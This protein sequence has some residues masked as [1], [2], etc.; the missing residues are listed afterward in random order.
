MV[1]KVPAKRGDGRSSFKKLNGYIAEEQRIDRDTGELVFRDVDSETNCLSLETAWKEM[2]AVGDMNPRVVDPVYHFVLSWP[3]SERPTNEEM[4]ECGRYSLKALGME[5]HQYVAAIH[6]DTDNKHLHV[7][8]NRV[9]PE[10]YKPVD[11]SHDFFKLHKACR[12]LE[13][14]HGW[15]HDKG[16]YRVIERDGQKIVERTPAEDRVKSDGQSVRGKAG[17]MEIY[18]GN[19]SLQRYAQGTPKKE[20]LEVLRKPDAQWEDLHACLAKHGLEIRPKGQGLGI[21]S[22]TDPKQMPIKAST[23]ATELG[24]G[25]IQKRL[26]EY[27]EPTKE[28]TTAQPERSYDASHPRDSR[29]REDAKQRRAA[30][31]KQFRDEYNKCRNEWRAARA[32][33]RA[34]MRQRHRE[35]FQEAAK[36]HKERRAEIRNSDRSATEKKALYSLA[37]FESMARK[38]Q[39]R[40]AAQSERTNFQN[41]A[42]KSFRDW[43]I[44]KANEGDAVALRHVRG[45]VMRGGANAQETD[46]YDQHRKDRDAYRNPYA[47]EYPYKRRAGH[48]GESAARNYERHAQQPSQQSQAESINSLRSLSGLDLDGGRAGGEMLLPRDEPDQL[49]HQRSG[50]V[51]ALR[52]ANHCGSNVI[53]RQP[54]EFWKMEMMDPMDEARSEQ[55]RIDDDKRRDEEHRYDEKKRD[56]DRRY[57]EKRLDEAK[58]YDEEKRYQEKREDEEKR[59]EPRDDRREERPEINVTYRDLTAE[60]RQ[61]W[62]QRQAQQEKEPGR[63]EFGPAAGEAFDHRPLHLHLSDRM[64]SDV[65]TATGHVKYTLDGREAFVDRG[66]RVAYLG[67]AQDK[68]AIEA[69][70][71]FAVEKFGKTIALKER[72]GSGFMERVL[73]VAVERKLDVEFSNPELERRRKEGLQQRDQRDAQPDRSRDA[74][75][76]VERSKVVVSFTD[77]K[78]EERRQKGVQQQEQERDHD[79]QPGH[80]AEE[81]ARQSD[82]HDDGTIDL[83]QMR[84]QGQLNEQKWRED[85]RYWDGQKREGDSK[86]TENQR[87]GDRAE[88]GDAGRPRQSEAPEQAPG[89]IRQLL[90]ERQETR[91]GQGQRGQAQEA[92]QQSPQR[93]STEQQAPGRIRQLLNERQETQSQNI[94]DH[95]R[96]R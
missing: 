3:K 27:R 51:D 52:R 56:E 53:E 69:G 9:N 80:Q 57:D 4:Y 6:N 7:S 33:A 95:S 66:D 19:E 46:I 79:P 43:T 78:L 21:Y 77:P 59:Y 81:P 70:T 8:A 61:Q 68:D 5:G 20:V 24:G 40:S 26:G 13:I 88:R 30:E 83:A 12:E 23:M 55:A 91:E 82:R 64:Q 17:E 84:E 72:E 11:V 92:G 85:A 90:N 44:A 16:A 34:E 15:K 67:N 50:G 41:G 39:L 31:N 76:A 94:D 73:E 2:K 36:S 22:A 87:D 32:P 28:I 71:K 14:E 18:T 63:A 48:D 54:K 45:R 10:T 62:E 47:R 37:A 89:R 60:Q 96:S 49:E 42:V 1:P 35:Q 74:V 38:E 25:K 93:E 86:L 58:R 75:T 65:N 29:T